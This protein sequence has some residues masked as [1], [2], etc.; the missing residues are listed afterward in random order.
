[1]ELPQLGPAGRRA[2]RGLFVEIERA[3]YDRVGIDRAFDPSLERVFQ[4]TIPPV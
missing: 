4:V 2:V 1:L 3:A